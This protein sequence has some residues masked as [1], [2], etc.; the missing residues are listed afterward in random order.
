MKI[1][2]TDHVGMAVMTEFWMLPRHHMAARQNEFEAR[3]V[4]QRQGRADINPN[5]GTVYH[6]RI[7]GYLLPR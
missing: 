4:W 6:S 5:A 2:N 7:D 1:L 3:T